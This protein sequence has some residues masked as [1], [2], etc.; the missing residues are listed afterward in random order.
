MKNTDLDIYFEKAHTKTVKTVRMIEALREMFDDLPED[1][2]IH[3]ANKIS[4]EA[5][6][7]R[8]HARAMHTKKEGLFY[9]EEDFGRLVNINNTW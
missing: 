4:T 9:S 2:R 7:M 8:V 3:M 1:V 5:K 6:E